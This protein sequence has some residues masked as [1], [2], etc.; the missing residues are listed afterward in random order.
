MSISNDLSA[1]LLFLVLLLRDEG[2][3][4]SHAEPHMN[5]QILS[6]I[7]HFPRLWTFVVAVGNS[8]CLLLLLLTP[9]V[10]GG[11]LCFSDSSHLLYLEDSGFLVK[12]VGVPLDQ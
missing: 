10:G 7:I 4:R 2:E 5:L 8:S 12:W 1:D 11:T 3:V 6:L 9:F